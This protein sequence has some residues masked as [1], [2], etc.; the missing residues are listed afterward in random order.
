MEEYQALLKLC[1]KAQREKVGYGCSSRD[2][3]FGNVVDRK[4]CAQLLDQRG[5]LL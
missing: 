1:N 4:P 5:R 3:S 2:L